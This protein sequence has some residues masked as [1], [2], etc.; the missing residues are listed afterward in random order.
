M[1]FDG[2][3]IWRFQTKNRTKTLLPNFQ[4]T[5]VGHQDPKAINWISPLYTV[6]ITQRK[7]WKKAFIWKLLE[8]CKTRT[9]KSSPDMFNF[10]VVLAG[11]DTAGIPH[12]GKNSKPHHYK[13]GTKIE[14]PSENMGF[15]GKTV[16]RFQT[17]KRTKTLIPNFQKTPVGHQ[18]PKAINWISPLYTVRI[19]QRK[20]WKKAFI[21]KL[22]E[23]CKTRAKKLSPDMFN[24]YV[25]LGGHNKT[26]DTCRV[27]TCRLIRKARS[28][29]TKCTKNK[30]P[31][32]NMSFSKKT[33]WRFQRKKKII[34]F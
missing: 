23:L 26:S 11:R 1:G 8:L 5:P 6:R 19:T 3:T 29:K 14:G 21:S 33:V 16:W 4:K 12:K 10:Y 28:L 17:K 18:D 13:K 32:E 20:T 25:V 34:H 7:T 2:K 24:F 31:F 9:K 30:G 15:N 22:L 27:T